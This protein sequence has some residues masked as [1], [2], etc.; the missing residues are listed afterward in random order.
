MGRGWII[1]FIVDFEITW[2]LVSLCERVRLYVTDA[3]ANSLWYKDAQETNG[4]LWYKDAQ[5]N[6][7]WYKGEP[8]LTVYAT[9]SIRNGIILYI[10]IFPFREV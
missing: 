9:I 1:E 5:A 7:L 4:L 6:S 2:T 10:F 8:R 3:Q